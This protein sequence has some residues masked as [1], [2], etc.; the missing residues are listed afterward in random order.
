MARPRRHVP[1]NRNSRAENELDL[2]VVA[3]AASPMAGQLAI[4][5][6]NIPVFD[7]HDVAGTA[8]DPSGKPGDSAIPLRRASRRP[9]HHG[10]YSVMRASEEP[11]PRATA[12]GL[13][14]GARHTGAGALLEA[15]VGVEVL[16]H[17]P[18][19]SSAAWHS[20]HGPHPAKRS[21]SPTCTIGLIVRHDV[22]DGVPANSLVDVLHGDPALWAGRL[23]RSRSPLPS[24][25]LSPT[26]SRG[27][28]VFHPAGGPCPRTFPFDK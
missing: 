27:G 25:A 26:R 23:D 9:I 28:T 14:L 16:A 20:R 19:S 2:P 21:P 13:Q 17:S 4:A 5:P 6:S 22:A 3:A 1:S 24:A 10:T 18:C 7:V 8:G 11:R 12:P 15:Q